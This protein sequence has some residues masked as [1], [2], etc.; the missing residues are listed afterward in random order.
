M[1]FIKPPCNPMLT[2]FITLMMLLSASITRA[3]DAGKYLGELIKK[4]R[5]LNLH[6]DLSWQ[7]FI[8]YKPIDA[9]IQISQIDDPAYFLSADG[10]TN[11][12]SELEATLSGLFRNDLEGDD[13]VACRF[14]LRTEWLKEK[15]NIDEN[16][17]PST[18]CKK[19]EKTLAAISPKKVTICYPDAYINSA[20]SMFGHTFLRIDNE[21]ENGLIGYAINYSAVTD[22]QP[23]LLYAFK[24][25]F[26]LYPGY[27]SVSPYYIKIKEYSELEHRDIWEY[28][29][30]LSEAETRNL[31]LHFW[32][33]RGKYSDYYFFDENC[34]FN[35]LYLVE[36]ARPTI[37]LTDRLP[38]ITI[39]TDTLR[40]L[41]K[42]GLISTVSFRPSLFTNL[43]YSLDKLDQDEQNIALEI[44]TGSF[45]PVAITNKSSASKNRDEILRSAS[46][47]N[48]FSFLSKSID[49]PTFTQR[50][51]SIRL[52]RNDLRIKTSD[53]TPVPLPVRPDEGHGTSRV[54]LSSGVSQGRLFSEISGRIAY[55][56]LMD[57]DEGYSKNGQMNFLDTIVRIYPDSEQLKIQRLHLIDIISLSPWSTMFKPL[58]WKLTTGLDNEI[59]TNGDEHLVYRLNVGFGYAYQASL[60][61][62]W[63][64]M[65]ETD[66]NITDSVRDKIMIGFG[67]TMGLIKSL[68]ERWKIG[69]F[70]SGYSFPLLTAHT[71]LQAVLTQNFKINRNNSLFLSISEL[72][73]FSHSRN[74]IKAG[75]NFYF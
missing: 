17:L 21:S 9:E 15:L 18:S 1:H 33:L 19:L 16:R 26:G 12:L 47:I 73:S 28:H 50:A 56:E 71:R 64:I 23:G 29:L 53:S 14:P 70:L 55:H 68:T 13:A 60:F 43:R 42:K 7:T 5:D 38:Y 63:F 44:A 65:P 6:R 36:A 39:P 22:D 40:L 3:D 8:H 11:S 20:P 35:I 59:M 52:A 25:I 31:V 24:G 75:W 57:P 62:M 67:G 54:G 69:L 30:T 48:Q 41:G 2:L 4:T 45:T 66:I 34:S 49:V 46:N 58:S 51:D 32:E 10:K 74:E 72:Q 61:G 27:F 37:R